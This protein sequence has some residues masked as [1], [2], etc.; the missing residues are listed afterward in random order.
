MTNNEKA[1]YW[2][3]LANYDFD[4]AYAMMETKR[5]LYV[6]FMC[7]QTIE[8]ILKAYFTKVTEQVPPF[9]H[10]LAR[11]A[12]KSGIFADFSQT[13]I[14]TIEMLEPLNIEARYP[15]YKEKLMKALSHSKCEAILSQ[16]KK[17]ER[18]DRREVINKVKRYSMELSKVLPV[19]QVIL[20]GSYARN[21]HHN[22]SDI[23]VAIILE[24]NDQDYFAVNALIRKARRT[25]DNNI[26][27]VIIERDKD[28]TG[29]LQ[30]IM[31]HGMVIFPSQTSEI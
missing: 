25:I 1:T 7:H 5:Y 23:D 3:E 27:P 26:E 15:T 14:E 22:D 21:E 18:M 28:Y 29:F 16:T 10:S 30:D 31:Q 13:Q 20:Y 12:E 9:T 2:Q 11:L 17:S 4:T 6:G 19:E 24:K 8:K